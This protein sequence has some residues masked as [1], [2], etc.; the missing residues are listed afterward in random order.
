MNRLLI[1]ANWLLPMLYLG[2]FIDYGA[3]FLLRTVRHG[4][5]LWLAGVCCLHVAFLI[6]LAQGLGRM[7]PA[8]NYEVLSVLA[9]CTA[10]I[11]WFIELMA[12]EGRTGVFV[13]LA[14]FV[15]QYTA[16]VFLPMADQPTGTAPAAQGL[17]EFHVL[18]SIV[19]YTSLTISAVYGLLHLA[20]WRNMRH[21]R[22]GV[23]FDRLPSLDVLGKMNWHAM[24][25]GLAFMTLAM[26]TGAVMYS[27]G[28]AHAHGPLDAKLWTKMLAGSLAWLLY[29]TT[30]AGKWIGGWSPAR[31]SMISIVA[32]VIVAGMF[33][34]TTLLS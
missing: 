19:A 28:A 10:T 20:S 12:H 5:L 22:F 6:A 17:S 2:L 26:V 31:V 8:N 27:A 30:A 23:L 11:Y 21:R 25:T 4:R 33:V 15:M 24:L 14:A 1:V 9:L 32:F 7:V 18:P 29:A 34:A 3:R 13:L 16:T